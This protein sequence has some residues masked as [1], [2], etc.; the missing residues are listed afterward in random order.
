M[1]ENDSALVR[2]K[3]EEGGIVRAVESSVLRSDDVEIRNLT[4]KSAENSAV[5]ILVGQQEQH[6]H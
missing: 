4:Q 3:L 6:G 1:S 5:E 2:S